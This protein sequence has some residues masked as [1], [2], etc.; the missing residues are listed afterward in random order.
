MA[1]LLSNCI[2]V[3]R[4]RGSIYT[5]RVRE[6]RGASHTARALTL[7]STDRLNNKRGRHAAAAGLGPPQ[8]MPL[9][10]AP[11]PAVIGQHHS[12]LPG[13]VDHLEH[14]SGRSASCRRRLRPAST[15]TAAASL[16]SSWTSLP[17]RELAD[18]A[19]QSGERQRRSHGVCTADFED[20]LRLR[21]RS[22]AA[23][24][25]PWGSEPARATLLPGAKSWCS[26][27]GGQSPKAGDAM[28]ASGVDVVVRL[29]PDRPL[30]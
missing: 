1:G 19:A 27:H 17:H 25:H 23:L 6:S 28:A 18:Q 22:L 2:D 4:T 14:Q 30:Q 8:P 13:R 7:T 26:L 5:R 24:L 3:A 10:S 16:G 21:G 9:A 11:R 15:A 29:F 12:S 20:A